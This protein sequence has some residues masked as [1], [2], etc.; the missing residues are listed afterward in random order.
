MKMLEYFYVRLQGY[1]VVILGIIFG[2][3]CFFLGRGVFFWDEG[4]FKAIYPEN[5]FFSF[6]G[7]RCFFLGRGGFKA[8]YPENFNFIH[9]FYFIFFYQKTQ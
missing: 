6:F 3:R 9:C 2:T 8:I 5:L 4:D 1:S 7:T